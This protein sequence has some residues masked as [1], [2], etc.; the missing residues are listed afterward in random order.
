[1]ALLNYTTQVAAEKTIG[2]IQTLLGRAGATGSSLEFHK[3]EP[4]ALGF[5]IAAAGGLLYFELPAN[6]DGVLETMQEQKRAGEISLPESRLTRAQACRVAWRII[7]D[8][9]EAQ[10]A[11]IESRQATLEQVM[12]PY[13][14]IEPNTT[15]FQKF[16]R[17][18]FALPEASK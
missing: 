3:S 16:E 6:I 9:L 7:K 11:L 2:Q 12:L 4:V 17:T 13:L 14:I 18:H 8:W 1:M 10:L 5:K 15:L